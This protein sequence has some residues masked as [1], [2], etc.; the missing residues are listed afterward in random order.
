MRTVSVMFC[1][2]TAIFLVSLV[3]TET[4]AQLLLVLARVMVGIMADIIVT[5][6][7]FIILYFLLFLILIEKILVGRYG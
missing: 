2:I 3:S 5:F 4:G 7:I 1:Y 6:L